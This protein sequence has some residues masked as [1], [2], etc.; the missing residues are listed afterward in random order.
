MQFAESFRD[1][2]FVVSDADARIRRGENL[3][4]FLL[5]AGGRFQTIPKGTNVK[6]DEVKVV[7]AGSLSSIIFGLAAAVDGS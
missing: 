2:T 4:A 7:E 6:I 1:K 5:D 3:M